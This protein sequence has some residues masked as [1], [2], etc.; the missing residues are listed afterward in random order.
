VHTD[1]VFPPIRQRWP[2][3]RNPVST[4]S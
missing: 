4:A 3:N 1:A 2:Q